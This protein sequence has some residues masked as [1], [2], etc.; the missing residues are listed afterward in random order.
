[1]VLF[2]GS[3]LLV[4][5]HDGLCYAVVSACSRVVTCYE[6]TYLLAVVI[7]VFCQFPK[8]VLVQI[9]IKGEVAAVKLV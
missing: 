9:R 8:C 3:F 7:V 4:M 1:M 6:G 5:L 2:C